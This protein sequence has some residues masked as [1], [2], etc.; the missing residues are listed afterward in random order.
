M[1]VIDSNWGK[2]IPLTIDHTKIDAG[3]TDFPLTVILNSDRAT[4]SD[5][6]SDG[7]D[8]RI[9]KEDGT[10]LNFEKEL[11][12]KTNSRS[13]W[14]GKVPS[15]SSTSDTALRVYFK[16]DSASDGQNATA[17]WDSD[18]ELVMHMD[19]TL[20]DSTSNGNNGTNYGSTLGLASD[21]Y[22]RSFDGV[23]D[24]VSMG[25]VSWYDT[26]SALSLMIAMVPYVG[27]DTWGGIIGKVAPTSYNGFH[28]NTAYDTKV[29]IHGLGDDS[30]LA[31]SDVTCEQLNIIHGVYTGS[32]IKIYRDGAL[33]E[34]DESLVNNVIDAGFNPLT[35]GKL[36]YASLYRTFDAYEVRISS[37]ARSDAWIKATS[38]SLADDLITYGDE[39]DLSSKPRVQVIFI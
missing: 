39:V 2:Y 16:N 31:W 5:M 19:D 15:V 22:Y 17:V 36:S 3:L 30:N 33:Q 38:A 13:V 10:I 28:I 14:H 12:D 18:Y 37:T 32:A 26:A 20:E 34:S 1:A 11:H 35:I 8:I 29:R 24:Y 25:D 6:Q 27:G 7:D 4:I 21:G 23:D 9:C